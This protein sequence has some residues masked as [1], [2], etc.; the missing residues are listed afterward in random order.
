[1]LY[2]CTCSIGNPHIAL[3]LEHHNR[4]SL[5]FADPDVEKSFIK[6]VKKIA[7]Y[8]TMPLERRPEQYFHSFRAISSS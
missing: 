5:L 8:Q 6:R 1:M 4:L 2:L 3:F 7:G